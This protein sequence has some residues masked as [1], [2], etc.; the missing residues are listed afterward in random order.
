[1]QM[2]N[3]AAEK[4]QTIQSAA[5]YM[6]SVFLH[7]HGVIFYSFSRKIMSSPEQYCAILL[8]RMEQKFPEKRLHSTKKKVLLLQENSHVLGKGIFQPLCET[9]EGGK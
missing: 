7:S 5:K 9:L 3:S 1:M 8:D 6:A 2:A 4:I